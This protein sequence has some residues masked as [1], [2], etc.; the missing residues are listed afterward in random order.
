MRAHAGNNYFPA[1]KG[2]SP[3]YFYIVNRSNTKKLY[4]CKGNHHYVF[5]MK[6]SLWDMTELLPLEAITL[7]PYPV[8]IGH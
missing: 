4:V 5:Y 1:N 3:G 8:Y 7:S 6:A 2:C